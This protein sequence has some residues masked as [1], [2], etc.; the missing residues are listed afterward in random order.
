MRRALWLALIIAILPVAGL[1]QSGLGERYRF[2]IDRTPVAAGEA[3]RVAALGDARLRNGVHLPAYAVDLP[4]AAGD[5]A[6]THDRPESLELDAALDRRHAS[7]LALWYS[8]AGWLLVPRSWKPAKGGVGANGSVALLFLP[9]AGEGHLSYYDP[10]ACIGCAQLAASAFFP[11]ARADARRNEFPHYLG[12][13]PAAK[14]TRLRPEVIAYRAVVDGLPV[15]GIAAYD[16]RRD[17]PFFKLE[18]ALPA[19]L[20]EL[21]R[22]ILN[23]RLPPRQR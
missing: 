1:A 22:P 2:E 19:E 5:A 3:L 11:E 20:R 8:H 10:S 13:E 16:A 7:R 6:W 14:L 18:V 17:L 23:W 15:D 12:T 4:Q 9:S 21:A